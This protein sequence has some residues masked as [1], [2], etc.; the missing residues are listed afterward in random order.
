MTAHR[1]WLK[2]L[3]SNLRRM[4]QAQAQEWLK[5]YNAELQ[6]TG[7]TMYHPSVRRLTGGFNSQSI[8]FLVVRKVFD[9]SKAA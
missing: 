3:T 4:S 7:P 8:N 1:A 9:K 5:E 6:A 2:T